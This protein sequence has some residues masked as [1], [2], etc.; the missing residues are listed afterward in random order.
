M[1]CFITMESIISQISSIKKGITKFYTYDYLYDGF[2]ELVKTLE[3]EGNKP[4]TAAEEYELGNLIRLLAKDSR[5]NN[6]SSANWIRYSARC[7]FCAD[8][9]VQYVDEKVQE[10][11]VEFLN[12]YFLELVNSGVVPIIEDGTSDKYIKINAA[13]KCCSDFYD[14]II[15][16][17]I[18]ESSR[19]RIWSADEMSLRY[20]YTLSIKR[21]ILKYVADYSEL[22]FL[23]KWLPQMNTV[24]L[25]KVWY[26]YP[27][28]PNYRHSGRYT[29]ASVEKSLDGMLEVHLELLSFWYSHNPIEMIDSFSCED[30]IEILEVTED[31]EFEKIL[32]HAITLP[33]NEKI[34][35]VLEHFIDDDEDHIVILSRELLQNY[36]KG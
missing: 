24:G 10:T 23:K 30:L 16:K 14:T 8:A 7:F 29:R 35:I 12:E 34:K 33:F 18:S 17:A 26:E 6:H 36:M 32:R 13:R 25:A 1:K 27:E 3:A 9:L 22:L 21:L 11:Q 4:L 5:Y 20:R 31:D 15:T 19:G 28:S 2:D